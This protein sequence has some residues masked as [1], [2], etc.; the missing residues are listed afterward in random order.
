M[1]EST[2]FTK[3]DLRSGFYQILVYPE[4]RERT[5][6]QTRWGTFQ[7]CV[8]PFGL[9]NA[10]ATF[11]RT[12]NS[13]LQEFHGFCEVYIDD[14]VVHSRTLEDHARDLALAL[15]KLEHETFFAKFLKCLFAAPTIEFCGC[16]VSAH[17]VATQPD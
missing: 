7:Y 5:A 17:G 2:I 6:F 10:P 13:L 14:I 8:M 4:H 15:A 12:M 1:R 9:C 16:L 11:Q 3:M